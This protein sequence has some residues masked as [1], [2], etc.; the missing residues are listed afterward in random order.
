[1]IDDRYIE[2]M[3]FE[4]DGVISPGEKLELEK[5]LAANP[6][7]KRYY[8]DLRHSVR[9]IGEAEDLDP[10]EALRS[11]IISSIFASREDGERE[12]FFHSAL[13]ALK[14]NFK[15]GYA[16]SFTAGLVAGIC[17]FSVI[18]WTTPRETPSD[19]ENFYGTLGIKGKTGRVLTSDPVDF[20]THA[21]SGSARVLY[22]E[23][24]ILAELNLSSDKEIRV[25]LHY[26]EEIHFNGFKPLCG[27][28][29]SMNVTRGRAVL[30]HVGTCGYVIAFKDSLRTHSTIRMEILADGGSIFDKEIFPRQR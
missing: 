4:I 6:N 9:M 5:Y 13:N 28:V 27:A 14:H 15:K 21:L 25:V 23:G 26:G 18:Y 19:L 22:P 20:S 11:R 10:P 12:G 8:E 30:T 17:I 7:A 2:L 1:M 16:F 3:N 24:A 29:N